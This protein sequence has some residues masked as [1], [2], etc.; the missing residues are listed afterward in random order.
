MSTSEDTAITTATTT[1]TATPEGDNAS[2]VVAAADVP[3][4]VAVAAA[5]PSGGGGGGGAAAADAVDGDIT[6]VPQAHAADLAARFQAILDADLS[7]STAEEQDFA[8][9][10]TAALAEANVEMEPQQLYT[11]VAFV[12]GFIFDTFKDEKE[13]VPMTIAELTDAIAFRKS[14]REQ[15]PALETPELRAA[16]EQY[17]DFGTAPPTPP[18]VEIMC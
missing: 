3:N 15:F 11:P 5:A 10:L 1:T 12:R 13:R 18:R 16:F 17:V 8:A 2:A 4:A 9:Q 14:I 6:V 7:Q